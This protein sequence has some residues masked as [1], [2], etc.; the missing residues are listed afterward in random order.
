ML[1]DKFI[2]QL[3]SIFNGFGVDISNVREVQKLFFERKSLV[4]L[5]KEVAFFDKRK[6]MTWINSG[7]NIREKLKKKQREIDETL[8]KLEK[9]AKDIP[10]I[11]QDEKQQ[12]M[13]VCQ[14]LRNRFKVDFISNFIMLYILSVITFPHFSSTRYPDGKIKPSH[15]KPG[16]GIVDCLDKIIEEVEHS[17]KFYTYFFT[18]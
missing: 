1:Q 8:E 7:K 18:P 10:Q 13:S 9:I 12:I 17:I 3:V 2:G 4:E 11:T 6:I 15:Y 14:L 16:L 5:E